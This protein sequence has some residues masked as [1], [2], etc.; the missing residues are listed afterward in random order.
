[1]EL[2]N[3]AGLRVGDHDTEARSLFPRNFEDADSNIS[4]VV[5]VSLEHPRIIHS[6]NVVAGKNQDVVGVGEVDEVKVL[7]DSVSSAAIPIRAFFASVRRK[8]EHA[9]ARAVEIPRAAAAQIVRAAC[10]G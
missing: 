2:G 8:N 6:I 5:L 1:M 3:A 10:I 4:I 7:I 9:A